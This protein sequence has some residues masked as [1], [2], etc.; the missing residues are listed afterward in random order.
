MIIFASPLLFICDLLIVKIFS[1]FVT[2]MFFR[3]LLCVILFLLIFVIRIVIFLLN[4]AVLKLL[5]IL[6]LENPQ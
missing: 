3:I 5:V 2:L 4:T 1:F 6:E